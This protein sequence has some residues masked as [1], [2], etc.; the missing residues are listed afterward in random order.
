MWE[1][2]VAHVLFCFVFCFCRATGQFLC[3]KFSPQWK[4]TWGRDYQVHCCL[5][6]HDEWQIL[7]AIQSDGSVHELYFSFI[8]L[9]TTSWTQ[10]LIFHLKWLGEFCL[11]L[12]PLFP[13]RPADFSCTWPQWA[14]SSCEMSWCLS[15]PPIPPGPQEPI[16]LSVSVFSLHVPRLSPFNTT[17]NHLMCITK[18]KTIHWHRDVWKN[19]I[20]FNWNFF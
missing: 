6:M 5:Q 7:F 9:T 13:C 3:G 11:L 8:T 17:W 20:Q 16:S 2:S 10:R 15:P 12:F 4:V 19:W 18:I 14:A 1:V